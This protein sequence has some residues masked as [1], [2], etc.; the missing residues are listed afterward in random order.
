[1][2][3]KVAVALVAAFALGV[4]GCGSSEPLTRAEL[5]RQVESACRQAQRTG[6]AE[7]RSSRGPNA[8]ISSIL[9][10]QRDLSS[11][12]EGLDPPDAARDDFETFKDGV[13]QRTELVERVESVR[14]QQQ[15]QRA[16]A[17]I[18]DEA[19]AVTERVQS[20]GRRLGIDGCF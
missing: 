14:G 1:M 13:E 16:M 19:T 5:V 2:H 11:K 17:A 12:L 18:E 3:R 4:A 8:F 15:M 9:A 7:M 6:Q 10:M 20:A